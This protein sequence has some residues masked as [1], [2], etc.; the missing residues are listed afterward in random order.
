[1]RLLKHRIRTPPRTEPG[2]AYS[3]RYGRA[4]TYA[5]ADPCVAHCET[6]VGIDASR[7][8]VVGVHPQR[9]AGGPFGEEF[10]GECCDQGLGVSATPMIWMGSH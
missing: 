4:F 5:P 6:E 9:D 2:P 1:M 10:S 8:V 3:V 7:G